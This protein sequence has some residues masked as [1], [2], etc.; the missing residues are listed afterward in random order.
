M[1]YF[2]QNM[3]TSSPDLLVLEN[4]SVRDINF[5]A[6]YVEKRT[7]GRVYTLWLKGI[8]VD[9]DQ[10]ARVTCSGLYKSVGN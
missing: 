1:F 8:L 10:G 6:N 4:C 7:T 9:R 3:L 5:W 2:V